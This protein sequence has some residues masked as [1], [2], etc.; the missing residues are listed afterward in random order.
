MIKAGFGRRSWT[1]LRSKYH[2]GIEGTEWF[3]QG[4]FA[5]GWMNGECIQAWWKCQPA[6]CEYYTGGSKDDGRWGHGKYYR[7]TRDY[8]NDFDVMKDGVR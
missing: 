3:D 4:A 2:N 7:T 8:E 1:K 5:R 6:I